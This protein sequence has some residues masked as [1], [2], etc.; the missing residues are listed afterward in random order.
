MSVDTQAVE[1]GTEEGFESAVTCVR[2]S[3]G[4]SGQRLD[5]CFADDPKAYSRAHVQRLIEQGAVSIDGVLCQQ[6][7]K[8]VRA[9]Q[10]I[11]VEWR[12][13]DADTAFVAEA[14]DL[15]IVYE[16]PDLLVLNKG[17][18]MVVHPAA[19]NWR[20]TLMNG[21]L[22]HHSN[23]ATLPRAGIVHRL[24]K[25]T[26]GLMVVAKTMETYHQLVAAIAQ[27]TVRRE[28][29]AVCHGAWKQAQ[30]VELPIGRDPKSRVRMAAL[31]SGREARTDFLPMLSSDD[32][33]L[34]HCQLHTGRTHQI[35]VHA[36]SCKHPLLADTLY[37]GRA[38]LGLDRQA[39]HATRLTLKHPRTGELMRW[40]QALPEDMEAACLQVWGGSSP[41]LPD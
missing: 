12:P 1:D 31:A 7:S 9:G 29:L 30:S 35:R 13:P 21:L 33:S 20:G 25:D 36:A 6:S 23:A 11:R 18:G 4:M 38:A 24:D 32:F 16:D 3:L 5:Q 34:V 37:G 22:A 2:V 26:S 17:P 41:D 27:R 8:R 19:G 15:P 10:E 14:M 39:L 40:Q 28:Y